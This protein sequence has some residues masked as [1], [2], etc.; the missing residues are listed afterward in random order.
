MQKGCDLDLGVLASSILSCVRAVGPLC[1]G[2]LHRRHSR[3]SFAHATLAAHTFDFVVLACAL[4]CRVSA[5]HTLLAHGLLHLLSCH[6]STAH[7][8]SRS[9]TRPTSLRSAAR[10]AADLLD[11]IMLARTMAFGIG[12]A[13]ALHAH[14]LLHLRICRFSANSL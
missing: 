13:D 7:A 4:P 6:V 10:L 9:R 5:A 3:I 11:R 2:L 8:S 1:E 14:H 12:T